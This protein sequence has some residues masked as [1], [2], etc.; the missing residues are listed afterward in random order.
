MLPQT[1]KPDQTKTR[2]KRSEVAQNLHPA[3]RGNGPRA[4]TDGV[5]A[6]VDQG[7]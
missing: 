6:E 1:K 4:V 7:E 3:R 5:E 2:R